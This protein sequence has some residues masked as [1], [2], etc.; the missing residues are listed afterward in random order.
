MGKPFQ[1]GRR[2]NLK[3]QAIVLS[4]SLHSQVV[5][6]GGTTKKTRKKTTTRG[7]WRGRGRSRPIPPILLS[8]T[9]LTA[10]GAGWFT[11]KAKSGGPPCGQNFMMK[12]VGCGTHRLRADGPNYLVLAPTTETKHH[13][14]SNF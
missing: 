7:R 4:S 12:G 13:N 9:A 2:T 8:K 11:R 10:G 14:L 5:L 1:N 3:V 6:A